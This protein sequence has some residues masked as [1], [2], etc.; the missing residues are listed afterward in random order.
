MGRDSRHKKVENHSTSGKSVTVKVKKVEIE[1]AALWCH[2]TTATVDHISEV[3]KARK[4]Q[5]YI[6]IFLLG[7]NL[8]YIWYIFRQ[9]LVY[10]L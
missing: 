10:S 8:V 5:H 1:F 9:D 3:V 2:C 7:I 6:S 4:M